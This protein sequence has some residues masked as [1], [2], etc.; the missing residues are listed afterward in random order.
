MKYFT[1]SF[2]PCDENDN[3]KKGIMDMA[4]DEDTRVDDPAAPAQPDQDRE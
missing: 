1:A 2:A 4:R 3:C